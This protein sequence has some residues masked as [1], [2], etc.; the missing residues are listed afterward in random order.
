MESVREECALK[1]RN[2]DAAAAGAS[3]AAEISLFWLQPFLNPSS[4]FTRSPGR[5]IW[6]ESR[7]GHLLSAAAAEYTAYSAAAV[8]SAQAETDV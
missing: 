6:I 7:L 1:A 5:G 2:T 3:R 4:V 8:D